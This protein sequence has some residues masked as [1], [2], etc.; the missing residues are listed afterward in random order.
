MGSST[1]NKSLAAGF[2]LDFEQNPERNPWGSLRT[3]TTS[4]RVYSYEHDRVL[5]PLDNLWLLGYPRS[6]S[7]D[8][9]KLG[10]L[11]KLAGSAWA[12]PTMGVCL[13]AAL[14]EADFPG[15]WSGR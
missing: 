5:S 2:Y 15:L 14:L 4:T 10:E 3:C 7:V 6:V 12:L 11:H 13:Y 1:T 8:G 9:L